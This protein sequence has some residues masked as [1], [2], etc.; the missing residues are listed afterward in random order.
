MMRPTAT[1]REQIIGALVRRRRS[2]A[3]LADLT[4]CTERTVQTRLDELIR[5]GLV[6][7][8]GK[9]GTTKSYGIATGEKAPFV[10]RPTDPVVQTLLAV[11]WLQVPEALVRA[12]EE[13]TS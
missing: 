10:E 5:D 2:I 12:C 3:E 4:G 13:A 7:A 11:K 9:L 6:D 8:A 1:A